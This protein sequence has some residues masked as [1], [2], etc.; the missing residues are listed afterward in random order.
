MENNKYLNT[1]EVEHYNRTEQKRRLHNL[2]V[3]SLGVVEFHEKPL[4]LRVFDS[5]FFFYS[6]SE[7]GVYSK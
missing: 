7:K 4:F 3:K 1:K 6:I 2:R 5:L